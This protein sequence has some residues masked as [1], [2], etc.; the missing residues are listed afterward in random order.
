MGKLSFL[1]CLFNCA[2]KKAV[3]VEKEFEVEILKKRTTG[4]T[5]EYLVKWK[6]C[7]PL[8]IFYCF[9]LT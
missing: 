1:N 4:P 3:D 7:S 6:G 8:V 9:S 2:N 5:T